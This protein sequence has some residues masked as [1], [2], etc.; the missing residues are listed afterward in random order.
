[1]PRTTEAESSLKDNDATT[2]KNSIGRRINPERKAKKR[3]EKKPESEDE[4]DYHVIAI[5]GCEDQIN[6]NTG[7]MEKR[8]LAEADGFP[9]KKFANIYFLSI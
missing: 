2:S 8:V 5:H 7:K 6:P 3:V 4:N 9:D 1:M